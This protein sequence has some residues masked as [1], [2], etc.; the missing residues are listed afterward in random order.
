MSLHL[1]PALDKLAGLAV[2][3]G[4]LQ[5]EPVHVNPLWR[6]VMDVLLAEPEDN[7]R[8][9]KRVVLSPLSLMTAIFDLVTR[10]WQITLSSAHPL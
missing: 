8:V 3:R 1:G 6:R 7:E 2:K 9:R 4:A 10:F 5:E